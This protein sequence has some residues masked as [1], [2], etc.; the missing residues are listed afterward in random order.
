MLLL[1]LLSQNIEYQVW[2]DK[3]M[4]LAAIRSVIRD[5]RK[6]IGQKYIVNISA[7]GYR[8]K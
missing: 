1:K 7:T 6:K 5:L 2:G 3:S 4:S 8:L